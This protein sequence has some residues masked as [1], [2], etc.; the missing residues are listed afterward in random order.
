MY[1]EKMAAKYASGAAAARARDMIG[2]GGPKD[3]TPEKERNKGVDWLHN[4]LFLVSLFPVLN[5]AV[6]PHLVLHHCLYVRS[7]A[8]SS[9]LKAV[10]PFS[11]AVK[12]IF[13]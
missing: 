2:P 8:F 1:F 9:F 7:G 3:S 5:P 4:A 10:V 6:R 12:D 11:K 13:G